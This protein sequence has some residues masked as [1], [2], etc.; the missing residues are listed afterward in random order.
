MNDAHAIALR[1]PA[2]RL[3]R[4]SMLVL[5]AGLL[6]VLTGFAILAL[7]VGRIFI[8]R[9]ELQNAAD[10]AA[11]AGANCLTRASDPASSS[12]C[13]P[14]LPGSLNWTRAAA[15]AAAQLASN[16]ADNL[17]LSATDAGHTI[18]VGYWNL[19]TK[20][21]S[22]GSFN[23][24]YSPI[25]TYDKPAVRVSVTKDTGVNNGPIAML[26]QLMYSGG[27]A[28]VPMAAQA[29]AVISSPSMV[30]PDSVI[31]QAINKCMY[32]QFW[33]ASTGQPVIYT[34]NPPDPYGISV[35]GQ[36][37]EVRIGSAYHYGSCSSGQWTSFNQ[38]VNSQSAISSLISNG[39]PIT[40][41]IGDPTWIE[42]GTKTASYND[43]EAK[44]PTPPGANVTVVVVDS[45][46]LSTKGTAPITAFA[47]FHISDIQGGSGKYIQGHFI[48][49]TVTPGSGIGPF[50]GSYTPP[51]LAY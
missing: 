22:G 17:A 37:W 49:S 23:I 36:P 46:D 10:S 42:P 45:T 41:N 4:G 21:P 35:V 1:R 7:D 31:P 15:R 2:R 29:V 34:G 6:L 43:L 44:Y 13:L 14:T 50:Y 26:T 8:V 5:C 51:R 47:G 24:N 38:D 16:S 32:D 33:N 11:L 30:F 9:N 40:L 39:N 3:L 19:L 25:G 28:G 20:A 18:E 12:N 48:P 27:G